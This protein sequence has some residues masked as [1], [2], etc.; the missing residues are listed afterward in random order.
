M[1]LEG[2][3]TRTDVRKR[4]GGLKLHVLEG[5]VWKWE[6]PEEEEAAAGTV[7]ALVAASELAHLASCCGVS[8]WGGVLSP[9]LHRVHPKPFSWIL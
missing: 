6:R 8:L 2:A 5:A 7:V 3:R 1:V 9:S 4:G